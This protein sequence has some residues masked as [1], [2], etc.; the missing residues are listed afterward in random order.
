MSRCSAQ[1]LNLMIALQERAQPR[2]SVR[3]PTTWPW[4]RHVSHR[5][6]VM[7]LGR[8][9]E[10]ADKRALFATTA[11]S[12]LGG[13]ARRRSGARPSAPQGQGRR[14]C[15]ATCRARCGRRAVAIFIPAAST[16]APSARS[17]I[18]RCS[19]WRRATTS[20]ASSAPAGPR[21]SRRANAAC[22]AS[23]ILASN[24]VLS[25]GLSNRNGGNSSAKC[26]GIATFAAA[27]GTC[28][29]PRRR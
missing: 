23:D 13:A 25:S 20:P 12:L 24:F 9:V 1:V 6:A 29:P 10:L 17:P 2:L 15:R 8:I 16:R 3:Q 28:R 26:C 11:A 19:R 7:Y 5:I 14:S 27:L 22:G 4:S 21:P 18:R